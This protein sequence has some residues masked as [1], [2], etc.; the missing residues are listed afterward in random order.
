M[1]GALLASTATTVAIFLPVFF[2]KDIEGQLFGDLALTIAIAVSVSLI[3]AVVLLPVLAK[4]FLKQQ[5][6]ED[7]N[8]KAWQRITTQLLNYCPI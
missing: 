2:L 3:V 6:A 5:S 1:W 7:P 4:Y 8:E